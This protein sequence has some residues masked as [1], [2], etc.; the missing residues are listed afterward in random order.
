ML[1]GGAEESSTP[2]RR[3]TA[4]RGPVLMYSEAFSQIVDNRSPHIECRPPKSP[5]PVSSPEN[6][7]S[8]EFSKRVFG[9]GLHSGTQDGL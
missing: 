2:I 6:G 5:L 4:N 7:A 9:R 1:Y 8:F 3:L